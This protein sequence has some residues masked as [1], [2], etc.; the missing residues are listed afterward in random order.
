[1]HGAMHAL[2]DV[3]FTSAPWFAVT[4]FTEKRN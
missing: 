1:M 2:A 4:H 3:V